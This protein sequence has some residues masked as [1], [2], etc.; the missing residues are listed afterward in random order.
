MRRRDF[1]ALLGAAAVASP[2]QL[3]AQQVKKSYRVAYLALAGNQDA[4]IVK[5][6]LDE[7]GYSEGRNLIFDFRTAEGRLE[8][9]PNWRWNLWKRA[10]T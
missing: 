5:Q 8:A 2:L 1:L 4:L 6:R 10:P 9:Y 3:R 7:L